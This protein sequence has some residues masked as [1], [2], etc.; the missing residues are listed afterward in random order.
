MDFDCLNGLR[1]LI[2]SPK[3]AAELWEVKRWIGGVP[4]FGPQ[5]TEK[6]DVSM[7]IISG[8]QVFKPKTAF[9]NSPFSRKRAFSVRKIACFHV[10]GFSARLKTEGP[11]AMNLRGETKLAPCSLWWQVRQMSQ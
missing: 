2:F 5:Q 7:G 8:I 1:W 9:V 3:V 11:N 10:R 4:F 6:W